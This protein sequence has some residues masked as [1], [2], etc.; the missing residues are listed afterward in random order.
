MRKSDDMFSPAKAAE[1]RD[2][3]I[4]R[5]ANKVILGF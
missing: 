2:E 5:M 3:V 4:H 1:R